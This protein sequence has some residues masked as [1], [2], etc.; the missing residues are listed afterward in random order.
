MQISLSKKII[1]FVTGITFCSFTTSAQQDPHYTQY[2]LNTLSIN[3]AYAGSKGYTL[4]TALGRWQWLGFEDAPETQLIS[5]DTDVGDSRIGLGFNLIND[6][7]GP[8]REFYF[9]G[10]VSYNIQ[11]R[12]GNLAVGL[13]LGGRV[14][15]VDWRI[16]NPNF[17]GNDPTFAQNI[18]NRFLPTIGAGIY[19]Y[20]SK[21]YFG[22]S[23]PNIFRQE[24]YDAKNPT[25]QVATE[26]MHY[27]LM[28]GYVFD[29]NETIK[30]KPAMLSKVVFGA[31]ISLDVSANFLINDRFNVGSSWRWD[32]AVALLLGVQA[33]DSLYI[34]YAYD[35]TTSNY[36]VVNNGTHEVLLQYKIFK[37]SRTESPRFF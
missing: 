27:F 1:L 7:I 22:V 20:E 37:Q 28:A 21:W 24:H 29:L 33:N 12:F 35:L 9:D 4:L 23:V 26:R 2:M 30:F 19:Y 32:D 6:K 31:P 11:T 18:T 15:N 25:G 13:K 5:Y 3:P 10:N 34:G 17:E 36:N 8:S 16:G 14:L